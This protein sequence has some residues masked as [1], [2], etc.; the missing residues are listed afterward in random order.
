MK[1]PV[2]SLALFL[3]L[4]VAILIGFNAQGAKKKKSAA[5]E[6]APHQPITTATP[7]PA[8]TLPGVS[9]ITDPTGD[10][11]TGSL[12]TVPTANG[13]QDITEVLVA[14]PFTP[15]G[16]ARLAFTMRV[17]DLSTLAPSG[18]W[19]IFFTAGGTTYFV[20]A[21]NDRVNGLQF[22]YGTSGTVTT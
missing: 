5:Q 17:A 8:C 12:G 19:R 9:L 2:R 15:D 20:G 16:V 6:R 13:S 7:P 11:G 1:T 4:L 18:I 3:T 14:E 21:F 22:N 10:T